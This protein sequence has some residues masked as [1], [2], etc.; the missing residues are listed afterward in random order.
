MSVLADTNILLRIAQRNHSQ[1]DAA[2]GSL[3]R[4]LEHGATV[5]FTL[6]NIAEFWNVATRPVRSNGFGYATTFAVQEIGKIEN[7]L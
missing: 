7:L 4:L 5:Y 2:I 6:Q 1:Y 3:E